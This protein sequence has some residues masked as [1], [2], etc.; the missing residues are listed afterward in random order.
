[1]ALVQIMTSSFKAQ[2]LLAVHDFRPSAQSGASIFKMALYTSSASLDAFTTAYT[3]S[4]EVVG[5]GYTAGGIILTNLGVTTSSLTST[6]GVGWLNFSDATWTTSTITA[7]GALIYNSTPKSHDNSDAVLTNPSVAVLDF[8]S[9]KS[10]T[11]GNFTVN[12][13]ASAY[14]TAILRVA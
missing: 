13:P 3:S 12:M 2:I 14:T 7:R 6:T 9:D 1:M 10:S 5:T 8:G 4:N 11:G